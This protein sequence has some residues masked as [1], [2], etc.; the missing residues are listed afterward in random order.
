MDAVLN[1]TSPFFG[2]PFDVDVF[3]KTKPFHCIPYRSLRC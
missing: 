3:K 1:I 2:L